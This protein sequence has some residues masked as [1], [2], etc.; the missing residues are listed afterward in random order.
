MYIGKQ[1]LGILIRKCEDNIKTDVRE[2]RW[3]GMDGIDLA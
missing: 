1:S 3:G 2:I